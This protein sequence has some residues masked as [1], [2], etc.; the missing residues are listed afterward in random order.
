[1]EK[2]TLRV[3]SHGLFMQTEKAGHVMP[4]RAG[5]PCGRVAIRAQDGII[6]ISLA[7]FFLPVMGEK[8]FEEAE[9]RSNGKKA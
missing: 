3:K 4:C 5:A 2:S 9:T 6:D 8:F 1:M 7:A